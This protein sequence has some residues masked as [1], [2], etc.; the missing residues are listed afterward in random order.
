MEGMA[1]LVILDEVFI[2]RPQGET[3]R[4]FALRLAAEAGFD[5]S[6]PIVYTYIPDK[7]QT[8]LT[9]SEDYR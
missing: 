7:F 5:L 4:E 8:L 9:Q 3:V 2:T 6:R 1:R